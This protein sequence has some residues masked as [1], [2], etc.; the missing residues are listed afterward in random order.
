[1]RLRRG[2]VQLR[3]GYWRLRR[4]CLALRAG[5]LQL[6]CGCLPDGGKSRA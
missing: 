1:M 2:C 4:G 3:C 6:R 5:P